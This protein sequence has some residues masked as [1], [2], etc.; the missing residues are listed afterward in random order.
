MKLHKRDDQGFTVI[1]LLVVIVIVCILVVFVMLAYSGVQ[2]KNHNTDRQSDIDT[3]KSQ[4]EDYYAEA[5]VYPTL[6]NLNDQAWR[7]KHLQHVS[8]GVLQDPQWKN[9]I[10]AC[11]ANGKP[12]ATSA[13]T[14]DCYSYQV[15][16]SDGSACDNSTIPCAHYT[17]TANLEGGEKYVK[18]SLN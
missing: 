5:N 17:L 6:A 3:L 13:P 12:V 7:T 4:L 14:V 15:A 18:S 2:V 10:A 9:T 16:G 8:A 1:E 11:T